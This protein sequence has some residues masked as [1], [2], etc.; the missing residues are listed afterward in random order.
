VS[1]VPKSN[2]FTRDTT[3]ERKTIWD[4]QGTAN[5]QKSSRIDLPEASQNLTLKHMHPMLITEVPEK[6]LNFGLQKLLSG[7]SFTESQLPS[8]I[9]FGR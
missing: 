9:A 2:I 6:L 8:K 1:H 5:M 3:S 4:P 7:S